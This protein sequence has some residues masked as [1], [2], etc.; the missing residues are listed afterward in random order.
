MRRLVPQYSLRNVGG[1]KFAICPVCGVRVK[2]GGPHPQNRGWTI[3]PHGPDP[4]TLCSGTNHTLSASVATF[5]R[6]T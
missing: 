6:L 2:L 5:D 4:N 1:E 3:L